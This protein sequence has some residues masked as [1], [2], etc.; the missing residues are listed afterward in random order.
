[1]DGIQ[2]ANRCGF[3]I[4]GFMSDFELKPVAMN[5]FR[6]EFQSVVLINDMM[7]L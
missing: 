5:M 2:I 1:M 7:I 3:D 4:D 6:S